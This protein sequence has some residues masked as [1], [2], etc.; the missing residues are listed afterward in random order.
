MAFNETT[1]T[2]SVFHFIS[3]NTIHGKLKPH[4]LT[5]NS[6][7]FKAINNIVGEFHLAPSNNMLYNTIATILYNK[8]GFHSVQEL[9]E[10]T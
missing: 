2:F 4:L 5:R 10:I 1:G 6:I 7:Q 8:R 9:V 3:E